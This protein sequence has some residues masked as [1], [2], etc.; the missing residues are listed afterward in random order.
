MAIGTNTTEA[1]P[2]VAVS[3]KQAVRKGAKLIVINPRRIPLVDLAHIWLRPY[4]GTNVA[5]LMGMAR[6]ILDE[7]LHNKAFIDERC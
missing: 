2:V 1:H 7:G 4:P 6:I 3:L 5:L